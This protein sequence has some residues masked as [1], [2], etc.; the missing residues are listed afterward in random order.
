[1]K[2]FCVAG[3]FCVGLGIV[4]ALT[5]PVSA[6]DGDSTQSLLVAV[7]PIEPFVYLSEGKPKGFS[8]DLIESIG[9]K[10]GKQIDYVKRD[11]VENVLDATK[12]GDADVAIAA[13]SITA[14]RE[15]SMDFSHPFY[16]SGL[17]IA[18]PSR[19]AAS[20]LSTLRRFASWE[21][22]SMLATLAGITLF[23]AHLLWVFERRTNPECF[24]AS[25]FAGVG[26]SLWWSIATIIT[27]GCE[28]KAPVTLWG[29]L[30]AVAWMLGSI[31]LVASFTA[32]L[33]SRMT[34]EAVIG[35]IDGPGALSGRT[36]ATVRGTVAENEL[37]TMEARVIPCPTLEHAMTA[38]MNGNAEAVVFDAPVL[39][40]MI[41]NTPAIAMHLVGPVFEH[42]DYGIAMAPGSDH[43][44]PIN[45]AILE[46]VESDEL[47]ELQLKWFGER[48]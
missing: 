17:R 19:N 4:A 2:R 33:A 46:L 34:S 12:R 23:A 16:R 45:Q 11:T 10:L 20:W 7:K 6:A 44:K 21:F 32:T 30:V 3:I 35:A 29:R 38:A 39:A 1:M 42:S 40:H 14:D 43:R 8:I 26:E 37:R 25:Y 18:V 31:V 48:E 41:A 28:N 5:T 15:A 22:L 9:R 47:A 36:V 13:I 27:G 24:P